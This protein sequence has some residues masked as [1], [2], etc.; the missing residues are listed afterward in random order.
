MTCH[1]LLPALAASL[2]FFSGTACV[3]GQ[4][5]LPL[6]LESIFAG[7][8]FDNRLP[9]NI[10]WH[11][12]SKRFTFTRTDPDTGLLDIHEYD[13]AA[14]ASRL[15][16]SGDALR[17]RNEP[18]G[19]T[20]CRWTADRRYILL[21]GPVSTTWD[22]RKEAAYYIHETGSGELWPLADNNPRL[23]NVQLS[24]N[25]ARV[26]YV[27]DNNIYVT[28]LDDRTTRAVTTD[29]DANIF[30][31]YF[32]YGSRMFGAG[33]AWSWSPDGNKIAF[34]RM[35]VTGVKV[36]Y[37]VDELGKYNTVRALKYPNTGERLAVT[38]IGMFDL[39]RGRTVWMDT[40]GNPDDYIPRVNWTNSSG[41]LAIQTQARDHDELVLLLADTATGKTGAIV[42]DTDTAWVEVTND[43]RFF[44]HR[45]RFVWTSEKSG[46]RHAYLYDYDGNE[47]QLT[48][49]DW[50][51]STLIALD[52]GAGWLY[53]Y[54]KKDS[55]IDQHVYRVKLDGSKLERL[56]H[57][58]GWHEW[59]FSPDR[60]LVIETRSDADT[61]PGMIL[62][63]ANG[64]EIGVL[65]AANSAALEK[66]TIPRA[67]FIKVET[68]DGILIDGYM[69]KPPDFD[70]GKKYPVI[71]HGYGNAGSQVVV[72][73]WVT[74]PWQQNTKQ[75]LW[76]RY[77]A[78]QGYI[79]F[80]VDN[81]TTAGRGKAAKNLTYGHYGKYAVLDYLE[82]VNYLKSLP[83]ID[84]DRLGFWGWS[85]GGYLAAALMTKGA[86]HFK[87]AVSIAPVIDLNRYQAYGVE[88][89]MDSYENNPQ[90]YYEVDLMNFADRLQGNLLLIHG[91]GDENV[92][93][94]FT[95]Q[96][97]HALIAAN[98]QF[99]MMIYP[100]QRHDLD[101]VRPHLFTRITD[102][103]LE[104]L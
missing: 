42:R 52:E 77:M 87:T 88:R 44:K 9:Q 81:R 22:G 12:D 98:K 69:I 50:E 35:D 99:D 66:Y 95:L 39:E 100:N 74:S 79:I 3:A 17:Y 84:P 23:L 47:T 53:F 63:K 78:A 92:K 4:D 51:I 34:W 75:D 40:G 43:L 68:G 13:V 102:Y 25:G 18:V 64:E 56:T 49:G 91:T 30:N 26:G 59:Q 11:S 93:Y 45:E 41:R 37:M 57:R 33:Q 96:L 62:R 86:P 97:A 46:Y 8:E 54:A 28:E 55:F 94:G 36:F 58:P 101:D 29:G 27:L 82:G 70:P 31:G 6:T 20:R 48:G 73:R 80:A 72:N 76:H 15:I 5:R 71:G 38:R 32:D 104:K 60:R 24:P 103:F 65:E 2:L 90:G 85:G 67:E 89:W 16:I 83:Y 10:Q 21:A 61:P 1:K 14:G 7:S 19:M